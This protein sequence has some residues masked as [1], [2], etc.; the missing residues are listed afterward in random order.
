M[1]AKLPHIA[2][3]TTMV[4]LLSTAG[5]VGTKRSIGE[6]HDAEGTGGE[7][8][9]AGGGTGGD[10]GSGDGTTASE[11]DPGATE[12]LAGAA[13]KRDGLCPTTYVGGVAAE[14]TL[15]LSAGSLVC[16]AVQPLWQEGDAH[17]WSVQLQLPF[18]EPGTYELSQHPEI[19]GLADLVDALGHGAMIVL[20]PFES[21]VLVLETVGPDMVTGRLSDVPPIV[22]DDPDYD[23]NDVE[24]DYNGPFE[25]VRC[26]EEDWLDY[27]PSE[28]HPED[29]DPDCKHP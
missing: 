5:C 21:G 6:Q 22:H 18:D 11:G 12:L 15:Q 17:K 26:A 16:N 24:Y 2:L 3:R 7:S 29:L 4:F 27:H 1:T 13:L 25:A 10:G 14:L 23:I 20:G 8:D 19:I 28:Y 9:D